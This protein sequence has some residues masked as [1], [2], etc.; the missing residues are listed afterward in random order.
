MGATA[1]A[2]VIGANGWL[3]ENTEVKEGAAAVIGVGAGRAAKLEI[4]VAAAA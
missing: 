3:I 4:E 2:V 1:A